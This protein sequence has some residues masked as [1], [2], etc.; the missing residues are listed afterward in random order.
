MNSEVVFLSI[1][2]LIFTLL[3]K[4][5]DSVAKGEIITN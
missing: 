4:T 1:V 5:N 3:I 2:K